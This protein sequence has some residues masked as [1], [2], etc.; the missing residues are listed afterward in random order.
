V[1]MRALPLLLAAVLGVAC[2]F[3]VACGDR[4]GLLP[5]ARADSMS[6]ALDDL[7]QAVDNGNCKTA[8]QALERARAEFAQLPRTVNARLRRTLRRGLNNLAQI[9]PDKCQANQTTTT[10]QETPTTT[11][12]TTTTTTTTTPPTTTT[13]PPTTTTTPPTTTTTTPTTSTQPTTTTTTPPA[14]NGNGNAGGNGNGNAGGNG[15]ATGNAGGNGNATGEA[16]G[17]AT[18][19]TGVNG[20]GGTPAGQEDNG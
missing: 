9:A 15:N 8:Q 7:Q 19:D 2:A 17:T 20:T 4:N 3:L 6:S 5:Q 18:G 16:G 10:T 14:G 13:T 12:P 11:A 1:R